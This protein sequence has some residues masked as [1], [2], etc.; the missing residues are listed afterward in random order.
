MH[1]DVL[2]YYSFFKYPVML[3]GELCPS[4]GHLQFYGG[5]FVQRHFVRGGGVL[6][7]GHYVLDSCTIETREPA[8]TACLL[9]LFASY[10]F[11][12]SSTLAEACE[13][14]RILLHNRKQVINGDIAWKLWAIAQVYKLVQRV[15]LTKKLCYCENDRAIR[16]IYG[17]P[18]N[19]GTTPTGIFPIFS[20]AFVHIDPMNVLTK[21]EVRS[22]TRFWDNGGTQN[23]GQS[24]DTLTLPFL[25]KF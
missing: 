21:F 24:M 25:D 20:A 5:H 16:L 23:V 3:L 12:S 19:V 8:W 7:R 15:C 17:C 11:V 4:G 18:K 14:Q 1:S 2:R 13:R 10:L 6:S 22:F 9:L